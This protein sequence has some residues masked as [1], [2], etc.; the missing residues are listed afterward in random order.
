[1]AK[2]PKVT[3]KTPTS[4]YVPPAQI[5]GTKTGPAFFL[6]GYLTEPSSPSNVRL[7]PQWNDPA[8]YVE[9][10]VSEVILLQSYGN[11]DPAFNKTNVSVSTDAQFDFP[12]EPLYTPP[13]GLVQLA[14]GGGA[15]ALLAAKSSAA[16]ATMPKFTLAKPQTKIP[17]PKIPFEQYPILSLQYDAQGNLTGGSGTDS[18]G[19]VH[20]FTIEAIS[21]NYGANGMNDRF[22][23]RHTSFFQ[24]DD[25]PVVF[26]AGV[27]VD[28][29]E[30]RFAIYKDNLLLEYDID[31]NASSVT[32]G[33][34]TRTLTW[35]G[36]VYSQENGIID[37]ATLA[38]TLTLPFETCFWPWLSYAEFFSEFANSRV[39]Q[40]AAQVAAA[41]GG[42]DPNAVAYFSGKTS[43]AAIAAAAV[44]GIFAAGAAVLTA[45]LVVGGIASYGAYTALIWGMCTFDG[46]LG[47]L[48][49][50]EAVMNSSL[51]GS[52]S[53]AGGG[54]SGSGPAS[55]G[56][57][58]PASSL[59]TD[60][61]TTP[62]T[63]TT[64]TVTITK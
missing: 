25:T 28:R 57:G 50:Y 63:N 48:V 40:W 2:N 19:V 58:Q 34:V 22:V 33:L 3:R 29:P 52:P 59:P 45:P 24:G 12:G 14:A 47:S 15:K 10:P 37:F 62:T 26:S 8:N 1:M 23:F 21:A 35:N 38:H 13:A 49:A 27:G 43:V 17:V 30:F 55:A 51:G 42:N 53:A 56:G 31:P 44:A 39:S 41:S 9:F 4:P 20:R 16:S 32:A 11:T 54:T 61:T 36:Q 18:N 5:V 46:A 6:M 64:P 7:H 60:K